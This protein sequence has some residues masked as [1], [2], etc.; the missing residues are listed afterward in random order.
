LLPAQDASNSVL[1][2]NDTGEVLIYAPSERQWRLAEEG[3]KE[4]EG[5]NVRE[6]DIET[7]ASPGRVHSTAMHNLLTMHALHA[8]D[9]YSAS[10]SMSLWLLRPTALHSVV[11]IACL[12]TLIACSFTCQ[13]PQL[14]CMHCMPVTLTAHC[15][16]HRD[17]RFPWLTHG[18]NLHCS[19]RKLN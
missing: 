4:T 16:R 5:A 13:G 2:V 10:Q 14:S 12:V 1:I 7:C 8:C 11:T 15:R 19:C 18:T 9:C 6:G 3:V 17:V